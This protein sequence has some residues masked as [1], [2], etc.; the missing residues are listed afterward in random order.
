MCVY[1]CVCGM[2]VYV[3]CVCVSVCVVYGVCVCVCG[4]CMSN[5][6]EEKLMNELR[7]RNTQHERR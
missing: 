2:C 6:K 5:N 4:M 1:M 7:E 3:W